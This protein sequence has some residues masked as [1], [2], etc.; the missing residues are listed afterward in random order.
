MYA[1]ILLFCSGHVVTMECVEK[2]IYPNNML[3]PLTGITLKDTDIVPLVRVSL[4]QANG[5]CCQ[6]FVSLYNA[7][8]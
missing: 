6:L 3:C 8:S 2:L 7:G 4:L 5:S 1:L